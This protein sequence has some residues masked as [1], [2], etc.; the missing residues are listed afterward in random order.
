LHDL[1]ASPAHQN[2]IGQWREMLIQKL[3]NRPEDFVQNDEL[4]AGQ[5]HG[6]L[7]PSQRLNI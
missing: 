6:G 7:I 3:D 1:I 5:S 4:T 2:R